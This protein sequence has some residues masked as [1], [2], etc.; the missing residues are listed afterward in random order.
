M[1]TDP[2]DLPQERLLSG[3]GGIRLAVPYKRIRCSK[4]WERDFPEAD[5]PVVWDSGYQGLYFPVFESGYIELGD[6]NHVLSDAQME[7]LRSKEILVES[8]I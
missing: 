5:P 8:M 2:Y 3:P 6:R 1:T 7:W 4:D